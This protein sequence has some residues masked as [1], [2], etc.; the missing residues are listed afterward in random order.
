MTSSLISQLGNLS[1]ENLN[2]ILDITD[3]KIL[4]DISISILSRKNKEAVL[5]LIQNDKIPKSLSFFL[6]KFIVRNKYWNMFLD[7]DYNKFDIHAENEYAIKWSCGY[8]QIDVVKHLVKKGANIHVLDDHP[9]MW[10]YI[11]GHVEIVKFLINSDLEYFS[12]NV[13]A[14]NI[15]KYDKLTEYYEKFGITA[16]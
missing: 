12:K 3:E 16:T 1:K 13:K 2:F 7:L 6:F 9:L 15:V 14:I 5:F 4:S 11:E 10:S 8:G